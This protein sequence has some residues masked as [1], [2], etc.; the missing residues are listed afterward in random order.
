M[1]LLLDNITDINQKYYIDTHKI[2]NYL[3]TYINRTNEYYSNS[4]VT[5]ICG[6]IMIMQGIVVSKKKHSAMTLKLSFTYILVS[7]LVKR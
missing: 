2:I 1:P 7:S 4:I 5:N 3:I 6:W